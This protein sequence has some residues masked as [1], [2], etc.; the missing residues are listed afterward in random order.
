MVFNHIVQPYFQIIA[1]CTEV[2]EGT[3]LEFRM[4]FNTKAECD[5]IKPYVVDANEQNMDRLQALLESII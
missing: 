1:T 4:K 3:H 2:E 5:A